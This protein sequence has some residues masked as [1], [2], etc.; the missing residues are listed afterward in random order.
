MVNSSTFNI[1]QYPMRNGSELTHSYPNHLVDSAPHFY[2]ERLS[3]SSLISSPES[4]GSG[5]DTS[6]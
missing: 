6:A 1:T 3:L 4:K 5:L 2:G